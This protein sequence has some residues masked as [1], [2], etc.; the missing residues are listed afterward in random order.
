[1]YHTEE[2]KDYSYVMI[3]LAVFTF[4]IH[5]SGTNI[6]A[7]FEYVLYLMIVYVNTQTNIVRKSILSDCSGMR[8]HLR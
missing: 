1:M 2:N 4:R 7:L 5:I 6:F 3:I 8:A